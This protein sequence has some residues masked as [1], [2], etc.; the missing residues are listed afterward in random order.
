MNF[1][2]K[3]IKLILGIVIG[4]VLISGISVYATSTYYASQVT[5]KDGKT[6]EQAL[7]ELYETKNYNYIIKDGK[8]NSN[9]TNLGV[10][11]DGGYSCSVDYSKNDFIQINQSGGTEMHAWNPYWD[12]IIDSNKYMIFLYMRYF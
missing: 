5:Y 3:N 6:V 11:S 12:L 7:N 4:A 9:V 2:K 10:Y 8:L 1:I